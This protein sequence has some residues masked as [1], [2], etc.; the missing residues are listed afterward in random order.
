MNA[1]TTITQKFQVH[2]PLAIRQAVGLTKPSQAKISAKA[3][4]IIIEPQISP[5]IKSAGKYKDKQPKTQ[6]NI[7]NIRDQ[8]DYSKA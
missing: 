7:D 5:I 2:I 8:V 3:G 1:T 4:K 6:V